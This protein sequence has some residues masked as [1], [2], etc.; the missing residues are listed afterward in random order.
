MLGAASL[1]DIARKG[2]DGISVRL[3]G[4]CVIGGGVINVDH[5]AASWSEHDEVRRI[6]ACVVAICL[7]TFY[8]DSWLW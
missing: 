4:R 8:A 6:N 7:I 5:E 3:C 2:Y 1:I